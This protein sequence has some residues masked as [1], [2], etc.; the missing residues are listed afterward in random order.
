MHLRDFESDSIGTIRIFSSFS[1]SCIFATGHSDSHGYEYHRLDLGFRRPIPDEGEQI[2]PV[3]KG[4]PSEPHVA[5][6]E[7]LE[8]AVHPVIDSMGFDSSATSFAIQDGTTVSVGPVPKTVAE[9]AFSP[10][11][12]MCEKPCICGGYA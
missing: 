1:T 2:R 7:L 11:W 9:C 12:T 4:R 10:S 6:Q 8:E 3:L 5:G